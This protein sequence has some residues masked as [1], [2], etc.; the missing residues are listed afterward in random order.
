MK[1]WKL[2]SA[3]IIA[4]LTVASCT[5]PSS[6]LAFHLEEK[7]SYAVKTRTGNGSFIVLDTL[8]ITGADH[9]ELTFDTARIISFLPISGELPVVHAVVGPGIRELEI[10]ADGIISGTPEN[11]WMGVQRRMQLDFLSFIDSLDAVKRTYE[12]SSTFVGLRA[13]D[14]AFFA[15]AD[16]YRTAL[17]AHLHDYPDHLSNLLAFY[18]RLGREPVVTFET[19]S[20]LLVQVL[21]ATKARY[22][23]NADVAAFEQQLNSYAEARLFT[24]T[25]EAAAEKFQPGAWF[26]SL[27]MEDLE[28][29]WKSF[30]AKSL[31]NAVVVLWASWCVPCRNELAQLSRWDVDQSNFIF[32]SLDGLPNQANAYADWVEAIDLHELRQGGTHLSDLKGQR[33]AAITALGVQ[34]LPLYFKVE[35]GRI[36]KRNA[37]LEA[38]LD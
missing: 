36:V 24:R 7:G 18:H 23:E 30:P 5:D 26:P 9:F 11:D 25:V 27:E 6:T 13:L 15:Y 3:G 20:A 28:R 31:D 29:R 34:D 4:S 32:I 12:D 38:V 22:P 35:S 2:W 19:D 16:N 33:S 14:S 37:S 21:Q 8:D 1:R 17:L 10:D